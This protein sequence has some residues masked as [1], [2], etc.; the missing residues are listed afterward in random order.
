MA[1]KERNKRSARKARAAERQALE[2][3][4]GES[5][6]AKPAAT[7]SSETKAVQKKKSD[8]FI[9]SV[10]GYFSAVRTEMRRVVWPSRDE[11]KNYSVSTIAMLLAV[12]LAVWLVDTGIM[13]VLTA[14]AA[15][16]G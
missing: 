15:L 13:L 3:V 16:R 5:T 12:G 10:K 6:S 1:N 8:G 11:L 14:L 9:A 4:Q 2:A 7:K